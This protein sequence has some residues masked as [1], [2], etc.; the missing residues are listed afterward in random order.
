MIFYPKKRVKVVKISYLEDGSKSDR[1]INSINYGEKRSIND[2]IDDPNCIENQ[3][4]YSRRTGFEI[5][6]K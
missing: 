5:I 6:I 4:Q 3:H 2:C 1:I